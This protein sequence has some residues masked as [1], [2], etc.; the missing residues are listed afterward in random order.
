MFSKIDVFKKFAIF[1]G[2]HL[3][4]SLFLINLQ[5]L[6]PSTLLKRDSNTDVCVNVAKFLRTVFLQNIPSGCFWTFE[7]FKLKRKRWIPLEYPKRMCRT[8]TKI[9]ISLRMLLRKAYIQ[10]KLTLTKS[11]SVGIWVVGIINQLFTTRGP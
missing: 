10:I 5:T 3:C 6:R 11:M 1:T 7:V 2:K 9:W 8:Y 4:W